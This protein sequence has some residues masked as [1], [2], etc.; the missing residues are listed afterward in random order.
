M[1]SYTGTTGVDTIIA[2]F[3]FPSNDTFYF[4]PT[5]LGGTDTVVGGG[6]ADRLVITAGGQ[7]TAAALANVTQVE[8]F[9]LSAAGNQIT[10]NAVNAERLERVAGVPTLSVV[11]GAGND[12]VDLRAIA[13]VNFASVLTLGGGSDIF[14]GSARADTFRVTAGD[15]DGDTIDGGAG[16]DTLL[17]A[18]PATLTAAMLA[19]VRG[20]EEVRGDGGALNLTLDAAFGTRNPGRL[21]VAA[22]FT[23]GNLITGFDD[24]IDASATA[25][26]V[27]V[28]AR[29]GEDRLLGG[30]G[31]DTFTFYSSFVRDD[32]LVTDL[33]GDIVTGGA[34]FDTI[35]F[36]SSFDRTAGDGIRETGFANVTGIE[37]IILLGSGTDLV[38]SDALVSASD[39][40]RI[41]VA[42]SDGDDRVDASAVVSV[43]NSIYVIAGAGDDTLIGS[44][45]DDR[46]AFAVD[47]LDAGDT[48]AGGAG[49]D[50]L[51]L[52]G[53]GTVSAATFDRVSG[54]EQVTL[55]AAGTYLTISNY[56][57]TRNATLLSIG[58]TD[59]DDYVDASQSVNAAR[60]IFVT[61]GAGDDSL[62]G[63]KGADTFRFAAARLS[64]ADV[65]DGG[66]GPERDTLQLTGGGTVTGD[67]LRHVAGIETIVLADAADLTLTDRLVAS[68]FTHGVRVYGSADGDVV[69]AAYVVAHG[70]YVVLSLGA[71]DDVLIGGAG[72][73]Y[74]NGGAGADRLTGGAG[75]DFFVFSAPLA[76][77]AFD[78]VTDYSVA[79]DTIQLDH[80]VFAGLPT[81]AL[82]PDAF[83][84]GTTATQADDR[85]LYDAASGALWFDADGSAAGAAVQIAQLSAGLALTAADIVVI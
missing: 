59:G 10:L 4:A 8:A 64:A 11:G 55:G 32:A 46:F 53:A 12:M 61:A 62:F 58:G 14:Y 30:T 27:I 25:Q 29:F 42:G 24:V 63:G 2:A 31:D 81:G 70:N 50:T 48:V 23:P 28:A 57:A 16:R 36:D 37:R 26:G 82:S 69:S 49:A 77:V 22:S 67:A 21:G 54:I 35:A 84:I 47:E 66:T 79:D 15:L 72:R 65:V 40:R 5:T 43:G 20:I 38:L 6:G 80:Q 75:A 52:S 18:G 41:S 78:T 3:P 68:A 76:G 74:L 1:A 51:L 9:V 34:G 39:T 19:N 17:V 33:D 85:I 83:V 44:A 13:A 56:A 71:G 7:I 60:A 45:G 73:D